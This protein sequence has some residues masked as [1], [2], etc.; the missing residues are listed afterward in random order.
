MDPVTY[1]Q[2]HF[3]AFWQ[4]SYPIDLWA[5][6]QEVVKVFEAHFFQWELN[7][8]LSEHDV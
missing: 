8:G 5:M 2:I 7:G 6:V 1:E 3:V 4:P